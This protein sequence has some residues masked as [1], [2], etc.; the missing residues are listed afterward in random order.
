LKELT[1]IFGEYRDSQLQI[2]QEKKESECKSA[3][4]VLSDTGSDQERGFQTAD[5]FNRRLD[6]ASGLTA[7]EP[8]AT[9]RLQSAF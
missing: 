2:G 1:A 6:E 5:E 3:K 4:E 9:V 8:D 7:N